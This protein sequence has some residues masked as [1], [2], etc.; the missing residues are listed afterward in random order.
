MNI[1]TIIFIFFKWCA[2]ISALMVVIAAN[3]IHSVL[4]LIMVFCNISALLLLIQVEFL[5]MV[6]LVVYVGAIAVL[7]L[8]V[9]MMLNIRLQEPREDFLYYLPIAAIVATL[10]MIQCAILLYGNLSSVELFNIAKQP[11][12]WAALVE[13]QLDISSLGEIIYNH[14]FLHF[15]IAGII[16]L[17]AMIGSIHLTL[18]KQFNVKKQ[19]IYKQL[20]RG[21]LISN[22]INNQK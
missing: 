3:P 14:F 8:F 6:L 22:T 12:D 2:L 9:V 11:E 18:S 4:F 13:A 16:L 20:S 5:A 1:E 10:F 17:V 19:F 21:S 7:F 15:E